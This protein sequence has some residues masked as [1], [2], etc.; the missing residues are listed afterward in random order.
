[1]AAH[2]GKTRNIQ[3]LCGTDHFRNLGMQMGRIM[4]LILE[5]GREEQI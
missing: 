3:I 2:I 5:G 1:L 4:K